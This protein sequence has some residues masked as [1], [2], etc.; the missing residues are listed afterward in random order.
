[1][2]YTARLTVTTLA[3]ALA[4]SGCASTPVAPQVASN[5]VLPGTQMY[6]VEAPGPIT[7]IEVYDSQQHK[8]VEADVLS[9]K[10]SE[11]R[12]RLTSMDTFISIEREEADGSFKY[13]GS[14]AKV[15]RGKYRV[16]FDFV[17][18]TTQKINYAEAKGAEPLGMIAVGLRITASLDTS[19]NSL[20]LGG[21]FPV[22]LAASNGKVTGSLSFHLYGVQNDKIYATVPT[23][24]ISLDLN[25]IQKAFE[26]AATV[27]A[28][29]GVDETKLEPYLIGVS[30]VKAG[31]AKK[32]IDAA[33]QQMVRK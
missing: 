33:T 7:T 14:S 6:P 13:L 20:D 32:I 21:L 24:P 22:G 29:I 28:L 12:A 30:Q 17:N 9:L 15:G 3:A 18:Y 26:S 19:A 16:I 23:I 4:F 27:R 5:S 1:M 11:I 2:R 8:R 31:D 25:G 10:S